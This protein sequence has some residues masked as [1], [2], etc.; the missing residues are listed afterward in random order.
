[1]AVT[2]GVNGMSVVHVGSGGVSIAPLNFCKFQAGPAVAV[3]PFPNSAQ[4]KDLVKGTRKVKCDAQSV[5]IDGSAFDPSKGDD[6]GRLGGVASGKN[7]GKAE[8][9]NFSFDV[10][11]EGK[12][13]ARAMDPMLHNDKNTPPVPVL[14]G[15]LLVTLAP[16]D[17]KRV[18]VIC[19]KEF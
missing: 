16:I 13:V 6:A 5:A 8:F 9:V 19:D 18:C 12:P 11:F 7:K 2:V 15:P 3:A 4:S 10:K 14:Q 1:M 17:E